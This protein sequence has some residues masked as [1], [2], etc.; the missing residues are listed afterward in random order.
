VVIPAILVVLSSGVMWM[1]L[2]VFAI[3]F[4]QQP[5]IR[6][7][8]MR[9]ISDYTSNAEA[10]AFSDEAAR[11][12]STGAP[13]RRPIGAQAVGMTSAAAAVIGSQAATA[14]KPSCF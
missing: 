4:S 8:L 7:V 10:R 5:E 9:E 14:S 1:L 6:R 13:G 12:A 2:T 11:T 3:A